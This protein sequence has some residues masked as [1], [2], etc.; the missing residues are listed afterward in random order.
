MS[1]DVRD[2]DRGDGAEEQGGRLP[3][4]AFPPGSKREVQENSTQPTGGDID[5]AFISPDDPMPA[6]E[7]AP[8]PP[9]EAA[10][11]REDVREA[12]I[13]S[14]DQPIAEVAAA[15]DD[16]AFI[17]PDEPIPH[18]DPVSMTGGFDMGDLDPGDVVVTGM[19]L[20]AHLDPSEL[21]MGGDPYVMELVEKVSKLAEALKHK[22]EAGLRTSPQM[23]K[24]DATLRGYCVGY[25]AGR[26][27]QEDPVPDF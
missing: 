23:D 9:E 4:P 17:S 10:P 12:L 5:S 15:A 27:A 22:G 13:P 25:L 14:G 7:E 26:R 16:D 19:G 1:D 24:F 11:M 18:R 6:R 2:S 3:P 8:R 20:D 21:A